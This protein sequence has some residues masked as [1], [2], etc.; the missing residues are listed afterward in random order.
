MK[1]KL[2][3]ARLLSLSC[4]RSFYVSRTKFSLYV[5][6]F[7]HVV[8]V[9]GYRSE[10]HRV[11][12]EDGYILK[13]HRLPPSKHSVQ[14]GS[15]FL[16]HGLYRNS[17]DFLASGP[18][19]CLTYY[20]ADNGYDVWLGNARGTKYCTEHETLSYDSDNFW[21]FSFHEIGLYDVPAMINF[22]LD[23]TKEDRTVYV[24]H[25]QG[26]SSLLALL[27]S[28][29]QFNAKITQAHLMTPAVFM[30]N[31]ISPLL[32]MPLVRSRLVMVCLVCFQCVIKY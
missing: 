23:H 12:T 27:S 30:R 21:K 3:N 18:N 6:E 11:K 28:K 20:L 24:G 2:L 17:A 14:R 25:S 19:N 13:V 8:N 9:A 5:D 4:V 29:P 1:W 10:S 32:T 22:M 26:C 16:M 7:S 15:V 31:S